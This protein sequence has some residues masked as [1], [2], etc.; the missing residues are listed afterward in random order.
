MIWNE[1]TI[2]EQVP[3]G[4]DS[5]GND[6]FT[7]SDVITL[8]ARETPPQDEITAL[9]GR[10]V[11][12]DVQTF[13]IPRKADSLPEMKL[14]RYK[15]QIFKVES[16]EELNPRYTTVRAVIY[17]IRITGSG[18]AESETV[19]TDGSGLDTTETDAGSRPEEQ[20]ESD[21]TN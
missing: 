4:K 16:V 13:A 2:V 5:L 14:I 8:K 17:V 9:E 3:N 19:N 7:L 20:S 12:K 6:I 11:T 21:N 18:R 10:S 15:G 1:L